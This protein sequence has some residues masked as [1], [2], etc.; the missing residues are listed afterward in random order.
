LDYFKKEI[1]NLNL[2]YRVSIQNFEDLYL[3]RDNDKE[4]ILQC[5]HNKIA[6]KVER[7]GIWFNTFIDEI[8]LAKKKEK[9][10]EKKITILIDGF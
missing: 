6:H 9:I 7:F 2:K 10:N 3:V 1:L 5:K 4:I 8:T